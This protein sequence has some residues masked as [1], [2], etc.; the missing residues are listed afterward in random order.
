MR[1]PTGLVMQLILDLTNPFR[2]ECGSVSWRIGSAK[3]A[4]S[5]D[6]GDDDGDHAVEKE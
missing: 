2:L 5:F 1:N 3:Q 4:W 6:I